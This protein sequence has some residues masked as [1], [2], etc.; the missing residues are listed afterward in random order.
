MRRRRCR[1]LSR[2]ICKP[3]GRG[4]QRIGFLRRIID[5]D[6]DHGLTPKGLNDTWPW[7]RVSEADDSGGRVSY[8]YFG[9]HQPN[10]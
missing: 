4:W 10:Q 9:E 7:S 3:F 1:P 6:V 8:V 5:A 2:P